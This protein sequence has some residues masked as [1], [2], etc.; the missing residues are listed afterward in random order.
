MPLGQHDSAAAVFSIQWEMRGTSSTAPEIGCVDCDLV[1]QA[2]DSGPR[3]RAV[4]A[5]LSSHA[6]ATILT[7]S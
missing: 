4:T 3:R 7:E 6:A 2:A 1:R 5:W